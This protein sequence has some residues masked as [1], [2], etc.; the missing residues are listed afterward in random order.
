MQYSE[1]QVRRA[2]ST[3]L[4]SFLQSQGE[5]L[6]KSG[7]EYRWMAHDSVTVR[8]NCWFRH[9]LSPSENLIFR[10]KFSPFLSIC[11]IEN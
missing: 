2:K 4:V 11:V 10:H 9:S 6:V 7:K 5:K 1:E 3:D 8:G